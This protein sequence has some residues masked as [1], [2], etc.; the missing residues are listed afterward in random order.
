MTYYAEWN[1]IYKGTY[2][3]RQQ[4]VVD[5]FKH[6]WKGYKETAWGHDHSHPISRRFDDWFKVGLTI[7]DSVDTILIMGLETGEPCCLKLQ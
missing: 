3:E 4:Y 2:N 6:A 5:M 7:L 1:P